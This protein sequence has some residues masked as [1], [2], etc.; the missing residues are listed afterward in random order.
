VKHGNGR[1]WW[2]ITG[3]ISTNKIYVFLLDPAGIHGPFETDMGY[4]FPGKEYQSVNSMAPD[5]QTYIRCDGNHGLYIYDFDRCQGILSNLRVLPFGDPKFFGFA[6]VFAS[7]SRHLYLSSW[8]MLGVLDLAAPDI[9]KSFDTLAYFDGKALPSPPFMTGFFVPNLAP[10]GKIYYA[11]T[12]GTFGLHLIHNPTLDGH[13]SDFEQHG[14]LLPKFNDGT[15]CQFPNYRLGRWAGSPCDTLPVHKPSFMAIDWYPPA[16]RKLDS[17]TLLPPLI[18]GGNAAPGKSAPEYR[19]S[20][21]ELARIQRSSRKKT[22]LQS[23][24]KTHE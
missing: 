8:Q 2:I 13:A 24:G 5:G 14:I 22:A 10:D 21:A 18:R 19:P 7:D 4:K 17:Y 16:I 9:G 15:M 6:S 23:A 12:N 20:M 11:T 3:E 1:D